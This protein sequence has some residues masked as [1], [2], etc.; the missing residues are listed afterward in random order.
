MFLFKYQWLVS[1]E[2]VDIMNEGRFINTHADLQVPPS[3]C[4]C[5]GQQTS[6]PT[7]FARKFE[8]SISQEIINQLDA[9]LFGSPA[10]GLPGLSA[11]WEN[12]YE[13]E[14]DSADGLTDAALSHYHAFARLGLE[15]AVAS[16]QG[17]AA[18][19]SCR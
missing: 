14:T 7:F 4:R 16:L 19:D 15:R 1:A 3:R 11:Y 8:A 2:D 17:R 12:I 9:H 18:N 13:A 5:S 6:R 10:P